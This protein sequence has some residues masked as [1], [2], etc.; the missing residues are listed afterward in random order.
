[1]ADGVVEDLVFQRQLQKIELSDWVLDRGNAETVAD[2]SLAWAEFRKPSPS[3]DCPLDAAHIELSTKAMQDVVTKTVIEKHSVSKGLTVRSA[4]SSA[5]ILAAEEHNELFAEE[6]DD[7]GDAND[8]D[9]RRAKDE[10]EWE[11][12]S[13]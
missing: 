7:I 2:E 8:V 12:V 4:S 10:L 5:W 11:T 13:A 3:L 1:M 6:D 9:Q